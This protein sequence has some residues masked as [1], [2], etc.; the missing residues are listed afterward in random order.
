MLETS[1][2]GYVVQVDVSA[3]FSR[4]SRSGLIYKRTYLAVGGRVLEICQ[5]FLID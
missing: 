1:C 2:A 5:E 4:V 3:A